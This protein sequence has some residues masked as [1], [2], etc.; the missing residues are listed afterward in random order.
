MN[1]RYS[2]YCGKFFWEMEKEK[3]P[4]H[5]LFHAILPSPIPTGMVK[6]ARVYLHL[7]MWS[8]ALWDEA[9]W[10]KCEIRPWLHRFSSASGLKKKNAKVGL[11][12]PLFSGIYHLRRTKIFRQDSFH[13]VPHT[14]KLPLPCVA[15]P[16]NMTSEVAT[17]GKREVRRYTGSQLWWFINYIHHI[18]SHFYQS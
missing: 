18:H 12:C 11:E 16:K 9:N 7:G 15:I 8:I 6:W 17:A 3:D 5:Y 2:S 4:K 1:R 13:P 14:C 10:T